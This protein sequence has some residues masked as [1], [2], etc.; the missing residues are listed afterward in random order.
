MS[1]LTTELRDLA[2]ELADLADPI[3]LGLYG[4][5]V[6]AT[7]KPDGS[8]VTAADREIEATLRRRIGDVLPDAVVFGEEDGVELTREGLCFVIDPIDGTKN[9]MRGV[10]VFATLIGVLLDG[11]VRDGV[12]GATGADVDLHRGWRRRTQLAH[13]RSH[14]VDALVAQLVGDLKVASLDLDPHGTPLCRRGSWAGS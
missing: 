5:P 4:G 14:P 1:S 12:G 6:A 3:A 2:L 8:P 7:R 13:E 11:E 9:F 10:P